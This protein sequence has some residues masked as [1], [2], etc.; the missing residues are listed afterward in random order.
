MFWINLS[1]SY[2]YIRRIIGELII[3]IWVYYFN[4]YPFLLI[5]GAFKRIK[6]RLKILWLPRGPGRP[7]V[8]ESIVD[9]ILDMKR[10]NWKWGSKRI[11]QELKLLGISVHKK[12]VTRILCENGIIPPRVRFNPPPW[13]ALI[14]PYKAKWALDFTCV[15]GSSGCQIFILVVIDYSTRE[16]VWVNTTLNPTRY[17]LVQQFRNIALENIIFPEA[18]I[19]DNDQIFGS[20]LIPL[21]RD[22]FDVEVFKIPVKCP[23]WNGRIERYHKSLKDEILKRIVIHDTQQVQRICALYKEYYNHRR[24]LQSLNGNTPV[25]QAISAQKVTK[26]SGYRKIF[27]CDGLITRFELAA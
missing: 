8:D 20:W 27:E 9:L 11:S 18:M 15:M 2:K 7:A 22:Y 17:W 23:W 6:M 4:P 3:D 25:N 1:L 14:E 5:I 21:R 19:V 24:P 16:L 13:R 10:S 26:I 12:T